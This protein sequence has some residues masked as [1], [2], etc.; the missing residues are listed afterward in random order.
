[1]C[2]LSDSAILLK[3]HLQVAGKCGGGHGAKAS[4]SFPS[5]EWQMCNAFTP[6]QKA[7]VL[8]PAEAEVMH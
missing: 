3:A 1:M 5:H 2:Q 8:A 7:T 6:R 4:A